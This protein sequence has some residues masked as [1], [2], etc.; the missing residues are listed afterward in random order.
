MTLILS[1]L[2]DLSRVVGIVIVLRVRLSGPGWKD[3]IKGPNPSYTLEPKLPEHKPH[4][5]R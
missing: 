2:Q 1:F 5:K 3:V 4:L